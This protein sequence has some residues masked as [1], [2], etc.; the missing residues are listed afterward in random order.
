MEL[1]EILGKCDHTLLKPDATWED[2]RQLCDEGLTWGVASVC[3][4]PCYVSQAAAY[5]E[6]RLPVTTVIGFP[7]GASCTAV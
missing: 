1:K 5:L 3:I 4:S 2:V 6:G 7:S